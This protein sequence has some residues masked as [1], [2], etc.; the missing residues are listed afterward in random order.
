M[1]VERKK[2]RKVLRNIHLENGKTQLNISNRISFLHSRRK[3]H[4][5]GKKSSW[6]LEV[7]DGTASEWLI[8]LDFV[9]FV[10]FLLSYVLLPVPPHI[11]QFDFGDDP[12]NSGDIIS[13]FCMV[14]KG[15]FPLKIKWTLNGHSLDQVDGITALQTNKRLSQLNIDSVQA[16]HSGKY[17]CSAKNP[18]GT[19]SYSAYLHVNGTYTLFPFPSF[20]ETASFHIWR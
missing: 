13:V 8:N 20:T 16:H 15:D 2:N 17:V 3:L 10:C 14:N 7:C 4:L 19:V 18:A 1:D 11:V 5:L 9:F 12:I 6:K